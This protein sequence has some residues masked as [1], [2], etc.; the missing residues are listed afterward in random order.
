M[1]VANPARCREKRLRYQRAVNRRIE[2]HGKSFTISPAVSRPV[3]K[4]KDAKTKPEVG[5]SGSRGSRRVFCRIPTPPRMAEFPVTQDGTC[6]VLDPRYDT[7]SICYIPVPVF[8]TNFFRITKERL[9]MVAYF[10][11]FGFH[12]IPFRFCL[13]QVLIKRR[14]FRKNSLDL[15]DKWRIEWFEGLFLALTTK[16]VL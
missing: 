8:T 13:I 7:S 2:L 1:T 15:K 6:G 5:Q 12:F 4:V 10:I 11:R 3:L 9:H 16:R 14:V